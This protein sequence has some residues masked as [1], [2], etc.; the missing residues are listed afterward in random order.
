MDIKFSSADDQ[1][2]ELLAKILDEGQVVD[3]SGHTDSAAI[4]LFSTNMEF[5]MGHGIPL[6]RVRETPV[7]FGLV[8]FCWITSGRVDLEFLERYGCRKYWEENAVD[9]KLGKVYG[10]Q[11][12]GNGAD[13]K[14]QLKIAIETLRKSPH[15]RRIIIDSWN[16]DDLDDMAL[17]PCHGTP[18]QFYARKKSPSELK[19]ID[20]ALATIS[21]G[22]LLTN[23]DKIRSTLYK[24][25]DRDEMYLDMKVGQRSADMI[26]GVP[27]NIQFYGMLL[28]IVAGLTGMKPGKFIWS[29][30][31]THVYANQMDVAEQIIGRYRLGNETAS[32]IKSV[33]GKS[34]GYKLVTPDSI[35]ASSIYSKR[36]QSS[37]R[38]QLVFKN[39]PTKDTDIDQF[40]ATLVDNIS[41]IVPPRFSKMAIPPMVK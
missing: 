39:P 10:L 28:T 9:G 23:P 26:H 34:D 11:W 37:V 29:G 16:A 7:R 36:D 1:Y 13:K 35:D 41:M 33:T 17:P 8:E 32:K 5:D 20:D 15:S 38:P 27:T 30:G 3:K 14:D 4:S 24:D 2:V 40:F 22:T 12:R 18:I 6:L 25:G 19:R 31:D 21:L